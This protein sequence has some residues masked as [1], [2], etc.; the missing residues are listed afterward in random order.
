M[1]LGDY[2]KYDESVETCLVWTKS[3]NSKT[4]YLIGKMA[5]NCFNTCGRN[6]YGVNI[7]KKR[8][9]IHNIIWE[10]FNGSIPE[11]MCVR[12]INP[13]GR[14]NIDNLEIIPRK[15]PSNPIKTRKRRGFN[16]FS[17]SVD[18]FNKRSKIAIDHA[19]IVTGK[20]IGRAHV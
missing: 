16:K 18:N 1:E 6:F 3:H 12:L 9:W 2:F 4:K 7:L 11:G 13:I 20:Q 14:P 17:E 5:G 19:Y 10:Y 15:Q 8:V